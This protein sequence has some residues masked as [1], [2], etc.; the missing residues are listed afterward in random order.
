[1][2]SAPHPY[3]STV[4]EALDIYR[5]AM[6]PFIVRN[7]K[8]VQGRNLKTAVFRAVQ[9][10]RA[11]I[12]D[13]ELN[14][15]KVIDEVLDIGD[16]PRLVKH[17]WQDGFKNAFKG[18]HS[19]RATLF[20]IAEVRNKVAHPGN[21][22][23]S[24]EAAQA[25]LCDIEK[26]LDAVRAL[27][28]CD[29]VRRKAQAITPFRTPAHCFHQGGRTVYAFPMDLKTLDDFLPE[30]VDDGIVRDA[31]RPLTPRHAGAIQAYLQERDDWLLGTLM[32]GMEPD[33]VSF[34]SSKDNPTVG[35]LTIQAHHARLMKMF[36]GQ[37]RRRAIKDV[38]RELSQGGG[39]GS[40]KLDVLSRECVPVLL[41]VE[42]SIN[43]LRQMFVDAAHTRPV[44]RNTVTLFD[45]RDPF[46]LAALCMATESD[47]FNGR[48]DMERTSVP[49]SSHNIIAINQLA[50]TLRT[51]ELGIAGRF[52]AARNDDL[53]RNLDALCDRCLVWADDFM[54][55]ARDEYN[56][57]MAGEIDNSDLPAQRKATMAFNATAIRIFAGC[58]H[59]WCNKD[60]GGQMNDWATLSSFIRQACLQP[61]LDRDNLFV[62][63]GLVPPGGTSPVGQRQAIRFT[64]EYITL[65]AGKQN[66][67]A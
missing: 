24:L 55:S 37:H 6:R 58:Y 16:F 13:S 9:D 59:E 21:A 36:D 40:R 44:E 43:A 17:Y 7:L 42:E 65:F 34:A 62:L 23:L 28:Q 35:Y 45:Q 47:L 30:R 27:E 63:T 38:L 56:D 2:S 11:S 14:G 53:V 5:T 41:Y 10:G 8:R 67:Q 48:V 39:E 22:D 49:R 12:I 66:Q 52:S 26:V 64:I 25:C 57:L 18:D 20:R 54:P 31:N 33:A 1:M 19:L 51:L 4:A 50:T 29:E 46:N 3:R 15:G 60:P 32:L 61:G